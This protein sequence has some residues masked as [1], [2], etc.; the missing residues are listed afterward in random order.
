MAIHVERLSGTEEQFNIGQLDTGCFVPKLF[1][2]GAAAL[3]LGIFSN[4]AWCETPIA[5]TA[6]EL[7]ANPQTYDGHLV[8]FRAQAEGD[9]FERSSL[10]DLRCKM[11]GIALTS[12]G[13]K[14][15]QGALERLFKS[16]HR[17]SQIS[18]AD[19][20][21]VVFVTMLGR[22]VYRPPGPEAYL[23]APLDAREIVIRSGRSLLPPIPPFR[24]PAQSDSNAAD[25]PPEKVHR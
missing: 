20:L 5:V 11:W 2:L 10:G 12:T 21:K 14:A 23:L 8:A 25:G 17:A 24:K 22:F 18:T 16:V 7:F 15:N 19:S 4:Q 13:E 9:W 6:C 3:V 1:S